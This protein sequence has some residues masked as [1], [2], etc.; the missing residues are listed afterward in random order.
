MRVSICVAQGLLL[1]GAM[2]QGHVWAQ[3][4]GSGPVAGIYSCVDNKGRKLTSD[5]PIA[6]CMDREQRVLN[7]SGTVKA[8]VGPSLTAR[9]RTEAEAR[10]K[11]EEDARALQI[12]QRR[13]ERALVLRYPNREVHDK[14]RAE[15]L[16]HVAAAQQAASQRIDELLVDRR[17]IE[18]EME[19][20]KKDPNRAPPALR[21]QMD[22]IAH[23]I[24]EQ[25][26]FLAERD[27]ETGRINARLDDEL[28]RL[29]QLWLAHSRPVTVTVTVPAP[30]AKKTP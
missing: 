21:R 22:D 19:F 28:G 4:D 14:E 24:D 27:N 20:Y 26:R 13:R 12:E 3:N 7:P 10:A 16:A 2:L 23:G 6:E 15:A 29:R 11:Q 30:S 18:E 17:K 1:S 5:R 25:K 8:K 9:E